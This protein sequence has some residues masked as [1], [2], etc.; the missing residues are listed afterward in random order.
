MDHV[1]EA[2]AVKKK[3]TIN[4]CPSCGAALAAFVSSCESCGHE[5]TDVEANRSITALVS[6][7]DDIE[8]DADEK[9]LKGKNRQQVILEKRARLIRDFPI[10]NSREDL[11]QLIYFIQPK[12]ADSVKPD[13]NVEDWRA[14]FTEVLNRAKHAYKHEASTLAEFER[15]EQSL[16]TSLTSKLQIRAKRNPLFVTLLG[17]IVVLGLIGIVSSQMAQSKLRKCEDRYVQGADVEKERLEKILASVQDEHKGKKYAEALAST[18]QL[19]WNYEESCKTDDSQKARH[20]WDEKREQMTAMIQRSA[21]ADTAEK[22]AQAERQSAEKAAE[23]DRLLAEKQAEV[24]K[25][26]ELARIQAEKER[27]KAVQAATTARTAATEKQ[28]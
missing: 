19:Q 26:A 4:K 8:Q 18:A 21:D 24:R 20:Q 28:W 15:I 13:P 3:G 25:E 6:R 16:N 7:F 23:Q 11:Q 27:A 9:G 17:G 10:P 12:I 14:K 1:T 5:F 2:P 22:K